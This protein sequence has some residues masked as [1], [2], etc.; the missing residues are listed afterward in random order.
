VNPPSARGR[1]VPRLEIGLVNNMPD[2]AVS[3]A[4]RQFRGR[5]EAL[6]PEFDIRVR[7]FRLQSVARSAFTLSKM[8]G[9]YEN[10]ARLAE[11]DLDAVIVTGAEPRAA[12]LR[13]EPY[14][15]EFEALVG[16]VVAR[17]LPCLW[18]CLAA[19]AAVL[20]L[21][22]VARRRLGVKRAGVFAWRRLEEPP[23]LAGLPPQGLTPHS[24]YNDL[25]ADDLAAKGYDIVSWSPRAGVDMFVKR[26]GGEFLFVQGHPEYEADTLLREYRRDLARW[27]EGEGP[28]P[29]VPSGYLPPALERTL[30]RLSSGHDRD[31]G[32]PRALALAGMLEEFRPAAAWMPAA[33]AIFASFARMAAC[34][35]ARRPASRVLAN[36]TGT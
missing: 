9:R 7:L 17:S 21:D 30:D 20:C 13:D 6:A 18:S 35:K 27:M 24:R 12:D 32:G 26:C 11:F 29:A 4:E 36:A 19:H 34:E 10:A 15:R 28:P 16:Q 31:A 14:W 33:T 1:P 5:L 3:A 22:G 2:G 25:A 8:N 23:A